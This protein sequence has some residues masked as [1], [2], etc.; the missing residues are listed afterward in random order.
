MADNKLN[1]SQW[2][3]SEV[4]GK[5]RKEYNDEIAKKC[6][7]DILFFAFAVL[8]E[9]LLTFVLRFTFLPRPENHSTKKLLYFYQRKIKCHLNWQRYSLRKTMWSQWK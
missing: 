7:G 6:E 5:I 8:F 1:P 3:I 4:S 2:S 9:F